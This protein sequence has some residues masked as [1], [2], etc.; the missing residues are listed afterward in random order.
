MRLHDR[1][2]VRARVRHACASLRLSD[3]CTPQAVSMFV[4]V[5]KSCIHTSIRYWVIISARPLIKP[6]NVA[7]LRRLAPSIAAWHS[8]RCRPPQLSLP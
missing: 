3:A 4:L 1:L 6:Q 5:C 7:R 8:V 2:L